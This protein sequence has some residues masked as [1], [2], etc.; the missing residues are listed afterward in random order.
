MTLL[1]AGPETVTAT[2]GCRIRVTT[3]AWSRRKDVT[4][5]RPCTVHLP[6]IEGEK[7]ATLVDEEPLR[8]LFAVHREQRMGGVTIGCSCIWCPAKSDGPLAA[9]FCGHLAAEVAQLIGGD[10]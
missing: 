3:H 9:Q 2:C 5:L 8:R 7:D 6:S 10:S 4:V 1:A